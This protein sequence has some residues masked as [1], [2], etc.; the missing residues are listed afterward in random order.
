MFREINCDTKIPLFYNAL[1]MLFYVYCLARLSSYE[2]LVTT[3]D[4]SG[5]GTDANVYVIMFGEK[6]ETGKSHLFISTSS[7]ICGFILRITTR[8]MTK[9]YSNS[10]LLLSSLE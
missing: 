6:G 5:A 1:I 3:G 4:V 8:S 7:N 9:K 2:V 10:N